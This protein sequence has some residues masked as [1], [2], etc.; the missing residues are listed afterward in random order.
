MLNGSFDDYNRSVIT[1]RYDGDSQPGE[2]STESTGEV[3]VVVE[4]AV[5]P[6]E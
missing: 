2:Q 5:L 3:E 6:E 4:T 1:T